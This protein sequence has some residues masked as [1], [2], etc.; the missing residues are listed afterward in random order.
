VAGETYNTD[1]AGVLTV[2]HPGRTASTALTAEQRRL[3]VDR[4]G[5][6]A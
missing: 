1:L 5:M 2:E 6:S 4:L 3:L